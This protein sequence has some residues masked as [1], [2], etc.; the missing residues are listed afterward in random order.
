MWESDKCYLSD[1][2]NSEEYE[3]IDTPKLCS[4]PL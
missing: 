4:Y 1:S 3:V 2:V